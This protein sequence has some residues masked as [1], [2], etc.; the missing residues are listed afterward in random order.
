[1]HEHGQARTRPP[2]RAKDRRKAGRLNP[3]GH[4]ALAVDHPPH[5]T[6]AVRAQRAP[7][8]AAKGGR[9]NRGVGGA[10][11]RVML[12]ANG[13]GSRPALASAE[14]SFTNTPS[15]ANC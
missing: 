9:V 15:A 6:L 11:H 4:A 12:L 2:A 3:R 13:T 1:P 8:L 5:L 10:F 14:A 7:A